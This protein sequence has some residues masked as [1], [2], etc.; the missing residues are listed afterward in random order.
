ML[1]TW[2]N[3]NIPILKQKFLAG[4][5]RSQHLSEEFNTS[6]LYIICPGLWKTF[7]NKRKK[8]GKQLSLTSL[9]TGIDLATIRPC[10]LAIQAH[11]EIMFLAPRRRELNKHV[12]GYF[13]IP[14]YDIFS[15]NRITFGFRMLQIS[16]VTWKKWLQLLQN[17]LD[18]ST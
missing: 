7:I 9:E 14:L 3:V 6:F 1:L 18:L 4:P 5:A 11:V 17:L 16:D 15:F 8:G 2:K 13:R 12:R 10:W